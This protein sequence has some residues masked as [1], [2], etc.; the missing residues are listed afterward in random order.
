MFNISVFQD[1]NPIQEIKKLSLIELIL[2]GG[3]GGQIIIGILFVLLILGIYIYF[4]RLFNIRS[5]LNIESEFMEQIKHYV[6]TGNL[7][8][9]KKICEVENIPVA[10]LIDRGISKVGKP[11][12]VISKTIENAGKLEIYNLE[13][14]ISILATISGIAPMIGFLGT[15]IGMIISIFE[16][17][18]SGGNIDMKLLSGGLYTAM[19]TTVGGLIVGIIAYIFY[20]HLVNKINKLVYQMEL[21]TFEF[22]ELLNQPLEQ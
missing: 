6:K 13:K 2:S 17:S 5:A 3:L 1:L 15:V 18:N 20:N 16:I 7:S 19:T 21:I 22:L 8:Q 14:N 12:D 4:E 9:A 11:L 10:R